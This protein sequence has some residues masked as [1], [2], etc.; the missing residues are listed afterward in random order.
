ME[1]NLLFVMLYNAIPPAIPPAKVKEKL[2]AVNPPKE[3]S[4]AIIFSSPIK[5]KNAASAAFFSPVESS[6]IMI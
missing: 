3:S 2:C 1:F 5:I 6:F 4:D